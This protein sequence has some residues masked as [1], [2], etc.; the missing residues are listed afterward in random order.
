LRT[1]LVWV[2]QTASLKG[3]RKGQQWEQL[4]VTKSAPPSRRSE[5]PTAQQMELPM[6]TLSEL[7]SVT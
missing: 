2:L 3:K 4:S 5:T 1:V 7:L 6:A